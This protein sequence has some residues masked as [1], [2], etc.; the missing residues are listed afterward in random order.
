RH[1]TLWAAVRGA[2][3]PTGYL[4]PR[5]SPALRAPPLF[6][7]A[8]HPIGGIV[9]V[10]SLISDAQ[11]ACSAPR[12]S[13]APRSEIKEEPKA[14]DIRG[15]EYPVAWAHALNITVIPPPQ[16][17]CNPETEESKK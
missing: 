9:S 13:G 1:G 5:M 2:I 17:S 6:R 15:G 7:C 11:R 16:H 14:G 12:V 4:S 8:R 3:P 10:Q